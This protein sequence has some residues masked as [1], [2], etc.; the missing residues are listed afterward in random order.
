MTVADNIL[1][2]D[3]ILLF[4]DSLLEFCFRQLIVR[5]NGPLS[6]TQDDITLHHNN[7]F[8]LGSALVDI[9]S[10]KC[11]IVKRAFAGYNSQQMKIILGKLIEKNDLFK[12]LKLVII[13]IGTND[14]STCENVKVSLPEYIKNMTEIIQVF[15]S[16]GIKVIVLGL[17]KYYP[18]IFIDFCPV[19][20]ENGYFLD[21]KVIN[22]YNT[23]LGHICK[24][25]GVS[26]LDLNA[27]MA[28]RDSTW[29]TDGIHLS[30]ICQYHVF[31][32][33]MAIIKRDYPELHP[34]NVTKKLPESYFV[35]LQELHNI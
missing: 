33:L 12:N 28:D 8:T 30:G 26:F 15:Q 20:V 22:D 32:Q 7:Q 34:E 4:G 17:P 2:Y 11:D 3:K 24:V 6:N 5:H 14:S 1:D 19:D 31:N 18:G 13:S 29:T 10:R 9:Y 16:L 35:T 27:L 23:S 25:S 21:N